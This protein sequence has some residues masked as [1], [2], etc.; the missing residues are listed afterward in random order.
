[1]RER[2]AEPPGLRLENVHHLLGRRSH[3]LGVGAHGQVDQRQGGGGGSGS[4]VAILLLLGL[5]IRSGVRWD[6]DWDWDWESSPGSLCPAF[7]SSFY[8]SGLVC[9]CL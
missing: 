7:G 8:K 9:V 5:R 4:R 6:W 1:M 2:R 3:E